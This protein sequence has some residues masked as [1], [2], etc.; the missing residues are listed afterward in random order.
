MKQF[1]C[2]QCGVTVSRPSWRTTQTHC[3]FACSVLGRKAR[4]HLRTDERARFWSKVQIGGLFDCWEWQGARDGAGYG[5]VWLSSQQ[6]QR[7]SRVAYMWAHG[8]TSL[9]A[10]VFVC[11]HCDNPRCVNPAHLFA[12]SPADN[13]A[14]RNAKGRTTHGAKHGMAKLTEAQIP[15]I[16]QR[17]VEGKT[18]R[19][20]ATEFGISQRVIGQIKNNT[21]WRHVPETSP[22]N[23]T[24]WVAR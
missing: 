3:S 5:A 16:R 19:Q 23:N 12:G 18:Q 20:I 9:S 24:S 15:A 14:D 10:D 8:L 7:S 13:S 22:T 1:V 11:H 2:E 6:Q 17:L 4:P 21:L